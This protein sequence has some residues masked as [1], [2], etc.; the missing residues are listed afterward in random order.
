MKSDRER[1]LNA[2]MDDFITK[3]ICIDELN[4]ILQREFVESE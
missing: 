4:A 1:C 3:P 2:G